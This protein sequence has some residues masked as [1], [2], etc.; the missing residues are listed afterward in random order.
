MTA[1]RVVGAASPTR[2]SPTN[3]I[4]GMTT[5]IFHFPPSPTT[6]ETTILLQY[7]SDV[8]NT[9]P[10]TPGENGE[11]VNEN[12]KD[13]QEPK[14]IRDMGG[15]VRFTIPGDGRRSVTFKD[16]KDKLDPQ[17]VLKRVDIKRVESIE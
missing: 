14:I 8:Y 6:S 15:K 10:N 7:D 9:P 1:A 3:V 17:V 13:P 5:P 12:S 16:L 2:S 4:Q 11:G